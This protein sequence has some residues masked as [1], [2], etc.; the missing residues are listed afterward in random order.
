MHKVNVTGIGKVHTCTVHCTTQTYSK[1]SQGKTDY[2]QS[3]DSVTFLTSSWEEWKTSAV[4]HSNLTSVI[5]LFKDSDVPT[6]VG[7][8]LAHFGRMP[9]LPPPMTIWMLGEAE[10]RFAGC[11]QEERSR[12]V[13]W[14]YC[15]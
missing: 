2:W 8:F 3:L 10:P 13:I 6:K 7:L 9:F 4:C 5:P 11:R 12:P 15:L 1:E 14:R